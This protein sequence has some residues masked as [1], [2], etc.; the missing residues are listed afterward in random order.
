MIR[1]RI[2]HVGRSISPIAIVIRGWSWCGSVRR[3]RS[4]REPKRK[5]TPY[6]CGNGCTNFC[7]F[8]CIFAIC[9]LAVSKIL[10]TAKNRLKTM[11]VWKLIFFKLLSLIVKEKLIWNFCFSRF[12]DVAKKFVLGVIHFGIIVLFSLFLSTFFFRFYTPILPL[13]KFALTVLFSFDT[14]GVLTMGSHYSSM[15]LQYSKSLFSAKCANI[16]ITLRR[17]RPTQVFFWLR[18]RLVSCYMA[19]PKSVAHTVFQCHLNKRQGF[20]TI[21]LLSGPI[22]VMFCDQVK[23]RVLNICFVIH[24]CS[25]PKC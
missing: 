2:G 7:D 15:S 8:V 21:L 17:A 25:V 4:R 18:V 11:F 13:N 23:I 10:T 3:L 16:K 14:F 6:E 12:R 22:R 19:N 24:V 5:Y 9:I 1:A 20:S